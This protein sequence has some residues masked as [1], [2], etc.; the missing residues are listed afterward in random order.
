MESKALSVLKQVYKDY[1]ESLEEDGHSPI[2]YSEAIDP[3]INSYHDKESLRNFRWDYSDANGTTKLQQALAFTQ[4][5][6]VGMNLVQ[7]LI[8]EERFKTVFKH[9]EMNYTEFTKA[10]TDP[11]IITLFHIIYEDLRSY[12]VYEALVNGEVKYVGKGKGDRLLHVSSGRSSSKKLNAVVLNGGSVEVRKIS[13]NLL[14]EDA[15]SIERETVRQY[16]R[17]GVDLYN[18]KPKDI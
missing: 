13:E 16:F 9:Y 5:V 4:G 14:E 11:A 6:A 17:E 1:G 7:D 15:L 12:Y 18:K 2:T 3:I 8:G 10:M